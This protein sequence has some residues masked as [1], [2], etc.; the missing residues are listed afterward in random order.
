MSAAGISAHGDEEK[1]AHRPANM[2]APAKA[3]QVV[4]SDEPSIRLG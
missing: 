3:T 4:N 2:A 1:M